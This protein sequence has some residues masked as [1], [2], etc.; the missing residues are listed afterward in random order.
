MPIAIVGELRPLFVN[1]WLRSGIVADQMP[2]SVLQAPHGH[3]RLMLYDES[4]W[5][6]RFFSGP[7]Y[8]CAQLMQPDRREEAPAASDRP[9]AAS[10]D[11]NGSSGDARTE[12]NEVP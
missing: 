4:S 10:S 5:Q 1:G 3:W 6:M 11:V 7:G 12:L 9:G 2:S 8:G